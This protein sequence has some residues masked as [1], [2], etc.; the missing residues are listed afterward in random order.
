[1]SDQALREIA[2][3]TETTGIDPAEG[4]RIVEIGAV[5]MINHLP[6]GKTFHAYMN[7]ER[8]M[9]PDAFAVHGLSDE[10][11]ADKPVFA[12]VADDFLAFIGDAPLIIHNAAFDLRFIDHE[13]S[14][15]G[16]PPLDRARVVDT[17]AMAR[18]MFPGSPSSLDALS[19]RFGIDT[20][21]RTLHGALLDSRI[22]A[23]VY[24]ELKGGR[25][26]RFELPAARETVAAEAAARG[27]GHARPRPAPLPPRLSEAEKAAHAAFVERLGEKSLW[28]RNRSETDIT[29]S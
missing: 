19:R 3:D 14:L 6:S 28:P 18:G 7:P 10:F 25:Q 2:L 4:H 26:P 24:L 15:L 1:M 23:E 12:A 16:R 20:S 27:A 22:L 8:M 29:V 5:E 17:L 11:L 9:P 13:L 21:A